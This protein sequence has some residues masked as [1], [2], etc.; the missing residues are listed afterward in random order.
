MKK[1]KRLSSFEFIRRFNKLGDK[2]SPKG[3]RIKIFWTARAGNIK[4]PTQQQAR[5]SK[6]KYKKIRRM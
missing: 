1:P 5:Y 3:A 6:P 2:S 4:I